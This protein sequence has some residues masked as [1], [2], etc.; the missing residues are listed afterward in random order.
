MASAGRVIVIAPITMYLQFKIRIIE[1]YYH[2][3][4]GQLSRF[5]EFS[6]QLSI[7]II[8]SL[9]VVKIQKI[10]NFLLQLPM[11]EGLLKVNKIRAIFSH[12]SI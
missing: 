12:F 10:L 3:G 11:R 1:E 4:L 9:C 7:I 8:A 2:I 5:S 6:Q